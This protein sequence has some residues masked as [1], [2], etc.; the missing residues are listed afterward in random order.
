MFKNG[1]THDLYVN[2]IVY[3]IYTPGQ[4]LFTHCGLTEY[5]EEDSE[6]SA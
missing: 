1:F 6:G 3:F 4:F 5:M 2:Y